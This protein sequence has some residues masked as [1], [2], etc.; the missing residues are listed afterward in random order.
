MK[1]FARWC[2]LLCLLPLAATAAP[3]LEGR[4]Y[5]RIIPAQPTDSPPGKVEVVELFWY[6]CP[7]CHRF[8]PYMERWVKRQGGKISYRRMPAILAPHWAIHARAYYTAQALGAL[9][10]THRA[11]F[12]A[13]HIHKRRLDTEER[14]AGFYAEHGVDKEEFK[15]VFHSFTVETQFRRAQE[16]SR[17][18]QVHATPSVVINGKYILNSEVPGGFNGML[19]I[20]DKLVKEELNARAGGA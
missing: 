7:H 5:Q 15:K 14:L 4:D 18:Y 3:L 8:Q 1:S 20:M 6:G 10:Q 13:I 9:E 12:D 16:M 2:F 17:R 11:L 19:R